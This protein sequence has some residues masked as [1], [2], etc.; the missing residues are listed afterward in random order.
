MMD[1]YTVRIRDLVGPI[2]AKA[3]FTDTE[4]IV[5]F[6]LSFWFIGNAS[7]MLPV[8]AVLLFLELIAEVQ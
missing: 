8:D 1:Y 5:L 3:Q 6:A 7:S 4:Y 2:H